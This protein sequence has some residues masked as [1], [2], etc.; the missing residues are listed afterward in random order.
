MIIK[1]QKLLIQVHHIHIV[2]VFQNYVKQN[3]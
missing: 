3:C 2:Q 1:D